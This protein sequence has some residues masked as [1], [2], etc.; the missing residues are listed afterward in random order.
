MSKILAVAALGL[1]AFAA[2][3]TVVLAGPPAFMNG[4]VMITPVPVPVAPFPVGPTQSNFNYYSTPSGYQSYSNSMWT[5]TPWGLSG[6]TSGGISA[7]PIVNGSM[8]SVYWDP[9]VGNYRYSTGYS[10]TPTIIQNYR[11]GPNVYQS[12]WNGPYNQ[13]WYMGR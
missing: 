8:H 7:R 10:N 11:Y 3:P 12:Y 1:T 6:F 13:R 4:G 9:T 2:L 5:P